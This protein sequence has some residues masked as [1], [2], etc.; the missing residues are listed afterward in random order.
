V[1][2]KQTSFVSL[3]LGVLVALF[4]G[5]SGWSTFS[6]MQAKAGEQKKAL[7]DFRK[8]RSTYEALVP[9]QKQ[10]SD[11]FKPAAQARDLFSLHSLM[12]SGL[13]TNMDLLVVEKL[14][15]LKVNDLE[16]GLSR[17]CLTTS[18]ENGVA[19]EGESFSTLLAE[20][21]KMAARSD[22]EM[23]QVKVFEHKGNPTALVTGF[24]LLLK[25]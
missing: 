13:K 11:T 16:L 14:D 18:G 7:E 22:I 3:M 20:V 5:M 10:W 6:A 4:F 12:G 24:C 21:R 2:P 9:V 23:G 1:L 15:R 19:F 8:W 25:D 17:I